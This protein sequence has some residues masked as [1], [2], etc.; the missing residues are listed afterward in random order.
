MPTNGIALI[1]PAKALDMVSRLPGQFVYLHPSFSYYLERFREE[2]HQAVS[3]LVP[4]WGL[5]GGAFEQASIL[6]G[7]MD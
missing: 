7:P 3:Y 1:E 5:G 4:P 6:A 2:P